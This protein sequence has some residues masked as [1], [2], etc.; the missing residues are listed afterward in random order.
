M[1]WFGSGSEK[2]YYWGEVFPP[3]RLQ[4]QPWLNVHELQ[5]GGQTLD[6]LEDPPHNAIIDIGFT[7]EDGYIYFL[8]KGPENTGGETSIYRVKEGA[9][10]RDG[11]D[12]DRES[13][14]V[15][16]LDNNL[17]HGGEKSYCM[18]NN[19]LYFIQPSLK[20]TSGLFRI[21]KLKN[22]DKEI[23]WRQEYLVPTLKF[24]LDEVGRTSL[25]LTYFDT[26]YSLLALEVSK[27]LEQERRE[28]PSPEEERKEWEEEFAKDAEKESEGEY[29]SE[30]EKL[31]IRDAMFGDEGR[32]YELSNNWGDL[33]HIQYEGYYSKLNHVL[34]ATAGLPPGTS[35]GFAVLPRSYIRNKYKFLSAEPGEERIYLKDIRNVTFHEGE[36]G[37]EALA[38][39]MFLKTPEKVEPG[40]I[41]I[42]SEKSNFI[43]F[44]GDRQGRPLWWKFA[45][46]LGRIAGR[47]AEKNLDESRAIMIF[48]EF[49][50]PDEAK[51]VR[52]KMRDEGKV[53]VDQTVVHGDYVDDRDT[54]VKDSVINRSSIGVGGDDKFSK[55]KELKEM[56]DS[57]FI[58]KEEM[59]EMK[60]E[61]LGK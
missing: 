43:Y 32:L 19:C 7:P 61:I 16:S 54:I 40:Y 55:L 21:P 18:N 39:D 10:L 34:I 29:V 3:L 22:I 12:R 47:N 50:F 58:S 28:T 14:M 30:A 41:E 11:F 56:F 60:K 53:K 38:V 20:K 23:L 13:Q 24:A 51:R 52:Q 35:L 2:K 4:L 6:P 17:F 31:L 44:L 42:K 37:N 9:S 49:S 45:R 25:M 5:L 1:G 36:P 27:Q 33:I 46:Q 59:E 57:G 26:D 48:E 8:I 15:M